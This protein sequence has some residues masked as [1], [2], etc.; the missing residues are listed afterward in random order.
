M[1][2]NKNIRTKLNNYL[3][4][5][6]WKLQVWTKIQYMFLQ[7]TTYSRICDSQLRTIVS[8]KYKKR[9]SDDS[10]SFFTFLKKKIHFGRHGIGNL[11]IHTTLN[12][13][14]STSNIS[15][16]PWCENIFSTI[17]RV[18][19]QIFVHQ[20]WNT[21]SGSNFSRTIVNTNNL[22]SRSWCND[23]RNAR[24]IFLRTAGHLLPIM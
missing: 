15:K 17:F 3:I 1:R 18:N 8:I 14:N 21:L 13:L 23:A 11:S 5:L 12:I 6:N 7:S 4:S 19:R 2:W 9:K 22:Y 16:I 24:R 20:W 10:F